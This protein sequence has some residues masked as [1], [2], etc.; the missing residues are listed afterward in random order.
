MR[1]ASTGRITLPGRRL[2]WVSRLAVDGLTSLAA[3]LTFFVALPL[4]LFLL[5][6]LLPFLTDLFKL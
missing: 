6:P 1:S 3:T 5:L 4:G 2:G